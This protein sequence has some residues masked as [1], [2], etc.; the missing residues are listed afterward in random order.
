MSEHDHEP[1]HEHDDPNPTLERNLERLLASASEPTRVPADTRARMLGRLREQTAAT[2]AASRSPAPHASLAH[3][4]PRTQARRRMLSR[5]SLAVALAAALL[6]AWLLGLGDRLVDTP[7][8]P[9]FA[10]IQHRNDAI[11]PQRVTL[12]DGS[13]ALLRAG[14]AL[15]E[16]GPRHLR[17]SAGEVLLDV[18]E[19]AEP[20]LVE[21]PQGRALVLGTRLLLRSE[22]ERTFAAVLRGQA[23]LVDGAGELL[24][25]AGEQ[26]ALTGTAPLALAG[27]RLTHEVEWAK[28]LLAAADDHE[29]VR[30]G[31]LIARVPRWTG[32]TGPSPEWPL[33]I[34]AMTVDVVIEG[35]HV[36]TTIDQTFFNPVA[37][38]L[39]GI[40]QFPLP[41]GA[42]VSRLAMY[43]DGQRMEA[44][45]VTREQGRDIYEQI[46]HTRRDPAL[47]EWM[48]GN[49]FQIRI[50]P[51]PGRTEKRV[52]LSYT[53]ALDELYGTGELRVP[54]PAIDHPVGELTYRIRVVGGARE[55]RLDPRSH[56]FELSSQGDDQ[57]AE[58]KAT[59]HA[60]GDDIALDLV[61]NA[62]PAEIQLQRLRLADGRRTLGV[63]LRPDLRALVDVSTEAPP[64]DV[65]VLFDTSASR[66]PAELDAQRRFAIGLIDQLDGR[67]RVSLLAFDSTVRSFASGLV[68]VDQ[69]DRSALASFLAQET[70]AGLGLSDLGGAID[71]AA[72]ELAAAPRLTDAPERAPV[73][74]L[75]GDGLAHAASRDQDA[76]ELRARMPSEARFVAVSFGQAYDQPL[77]ARLAALGEGV[78]LH[79][80]EGESDMA[81]QA[82]EL[83]SRLS[84]PRLLDLE[85]RLLDG[86]G[87]AIA[88]RTTHADTRSLAEGERLTVFAELAA[89]EPDP[90]SIELAGAVVGPATIPGRPRERWTV[91]HAL[92]AALEQ[93]RWLPRAWARAHVAALIDEGVE[94]NREAITA[95][96][97]EHFLVT[98]TTS[99][100]VLENEAMY[101]EFDV[102]RPPLDAWAAYEAP[103]RIEV[104]REGPAIVDEGELIARTPVG[105]LVDYGNSQSIVARRTRGFGSLQPDATI[106]LG[107]LG[108]IG[109]GRGGGGTGVGGFGFGLR[110]NS[111]PK[112]EFKK[113]G[114][115]SLE[116]GR[117][118]NQQ[119]SWGWAAG[120]TTGGLA[121]PMV[122]AALDLPNSGFSAAFVGGARLDRS[123]PWPQAMYWTGDVRLD[124]LGEQV[125]ALF[126][127]A[128]DVQREELLLDLLDERGQDAVRGSVSEAARERIAASRA[129]STNLR[130]RLPEGGELDIDGEGRFALVQT[131][132][133]ALVEHVT[134]DGESLRADHP[135]LGLSVVRAVG[136][137]S[138]ALL[139]RWVP[140]LIPKAEHLERFY[141]VEL[142][143]PNRLVLRP[144]AP[145]SSTSEP[146]P[147]A[148]RLE[149]AL[150][151]Q[152]R[153]SAI[154]LW[155][156]EYLRSKTSFA[157]TDASLT[158]ESER[159]RA[160][161]Q[162]L[163]RVAG[164]ARRIAELGREQATRVALPLRSPASLE[165]ALGRETPG[166]AAW[167]AIQQQRLASLAAIANHGALLPVLDQLREHAGRVLPGELALAGAGVAL[168]SDA[169]LV[170]RVLASA[171]AS[172][173][174]SRVAAYLRA[175]IRSRKGDAKPM[176]A[177]VKSERGSPIGMLASYRVL[178]H[179]TERRVSVKSMPTLTTFLADYT[180]PAFAFVATQRVAN[181][182]W[183]STKA[184][185]AAWLALAEHEGPW[186]LRAMH[187]AAGTLYGSDDARAA[188]LFLQAFER[189]REHDEVP[190]IDWRAQW[191]IRNTLGDAGWELMWTRLRERVAKS[192]DPHQ[193]LAFLDAAWQVGRLDEAPR[194]LEQLDAAAID[195]DTGLAL[196]DTLTTL[197][198]VHEAN[199]VLQT[200]VA[201]L[202]DDPAVLL[203]ASSAAEQQGRLREAAETL[204]RALDRALAGEGMTLDELR[205]GYAR[206]FELRARLAR[207]IAGSS[208]D[209]EA[210]RAALAT[211]DRWRLEDP[212]NGEIDRLCADLLWSLGRDAEAWRALS[213]VIDRH[214]QEGEALA[215]LANALER[216][217]ELERA[218][219]VW[220]RAILV[221]PTEPTHRLRRAQN[222]LG[223][224]QDGEA[225]ELLADIREGE[226]Q[227]RFDFVVTQA[228]QLE[229]LVVSRDE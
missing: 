166:S 125:P 51:L 30:R 52:L 28:P 98:P 200:I 19:A 48:Q 58:F 198:R 9:S 83:F 73:L 75:L 4:D 20:L 59:N 199:A 153:V 228:K 22:A 165:H 201:Q 179:E 32:Q 18:V 130:F 2:R 195:V 226:W 11:A 133:K 188:E 138:P 67:D 225:A 6:L 190:L 85:V 220:Q 23:K 181:G 117:F 17:L 126:E 120:E 189:A 102:H 209:A 213:S 210:L 204:D 136:P 180:H 217:G 176:R 203:R 26:A 109:S 194:V 49:L 64:R 82:L 129:A 90:V 175:G 21:T 186:T 107:S 47:L 101:R 74:V 63:T 13:I 219:S 141:T 154:E 54:I 29:V 15:D 53:Q 8:P 214:P 118:A 84:T 192:G 70:R 197:G 205:S 91:T 122:P 171:E 173:P 113:S 96:G 45:V 211:A 123:M 24:L 207:P 164:P 121:G 94:P 168:T 149:V 139:E 5:A 143:S 224:E 42:A 10:T 114:I 103:D 183:S 202:P 86:S 174:D 132:W 110:G 177:L 33:P 80:P 124:D 134:Y 187:E 76:L 16:L 14:A 115:K 127:D 147:P 78:H 172:A 111:L 178:L 105:I 160:R 169:E 167:V 93:A 87:A 39:E 44:G 216:A 157:W 72:L 57:I 27:R 1:E 50:F 60:I 46:V 206:L 62:A 196:Y 92:P 88:T 148:L 97:L 193:A 227:P 65:V 35:G 69:L 151:E 128:F 170:E 7:E 79:V 163:E 108:L 34:R 155:A 191:S 185:S 182:L 36:R 152:A 184:R 131:R 71:Q 150:D 137:T 158:I 229:K 159:P 61:P 66:G 68:G 89:N 145:V 43:V 37:R 221:E 40:Y 140:W 146:T 223:R 55:V 116:S 135:Q 99:L 112:S 212:D 162:V 142:A 41:S 218:D 119:T 161:A 222:L 144:L 12:A 56:A 81:W 25:R 104:V 215:W 31:N 100:L 38:Q 95:L 208:A 106:G 3:P 156:G 77:L